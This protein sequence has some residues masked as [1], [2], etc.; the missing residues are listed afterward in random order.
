MLDAAVTLGPLRLSWDLKWWSWKSPA[1]GL[2]AVWYGAGGDSGTPVLHIA[3][4]I[5]PAT[6]SLFI[7][8]RD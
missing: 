8:W 1:L 3:G 7:W 6:G 2:L 5:G 4:G